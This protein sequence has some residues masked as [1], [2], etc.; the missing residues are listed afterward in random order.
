M[1]LITFVFVYVW[2]AF[3][4][5]CICLFWF[6]KLLVIFTSYFNKNML[7]KS[8]P[9]YIILPYTLLTTNYNRNKFQLSKDMLIVEGHL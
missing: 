8:P 2:D 6:R 1:N 3:F 5:I 9:T 7:E 4:A